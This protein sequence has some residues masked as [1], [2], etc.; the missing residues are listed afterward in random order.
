MNTVRTAR[1][2]MISALAAGALGLAGVCAQAQGAAAWPSQ[3]VKILVGFPGGSTPDV[4]ARVLAEAL[5]KAWGQTVL[6]ENRPGAAG[7]IAA[8]AVAKSRDAHTLGVVIN[9]NLTTAPLL[10]PKLPFDPAKDF[11]FISLLGTAPLVMVT[12]ADKP[13]GADFFAA[14]RAGG[15]EAGGGSLGRS[16]FSLSGQSRNPR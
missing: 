14:A 1:R 7:N 12:N 13:A 9:G 15:E 4:A 8:D 5:A 16:S 3:P 11:S 2:L 6:V 10:N